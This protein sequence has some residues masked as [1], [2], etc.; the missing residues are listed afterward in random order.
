MY[1]RLKS[2]PLLGEELRYDLKENKVYRVDFV[3]LAASGSS[4]DEAVWAILKITYDGCGLPARE[5]VFANV[6]W[7]TREAL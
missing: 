4:P 2:G 7:A 5:E 1:N 6:A 3:G